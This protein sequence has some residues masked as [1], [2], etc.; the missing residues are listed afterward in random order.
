MKQYMQLPGKPQQTYIHRDILSFSAHLFSHSVDFTICKSKILNSLTSAWTPCQHRDL[1]E[2]WFTFHRQH[3]L[4]ES[5]RE[6]L[7]AVIAT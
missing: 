6:T 2:A 1:N 4:A 5:Y 3:G 7:L